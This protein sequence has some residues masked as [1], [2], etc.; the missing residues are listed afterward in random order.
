[1]TGID[2]DWQQAELDFAY[3]LE[4]SSSIY[5]DRRPAASLNRQRF[6][7]PNQLESRLAENARRLAHRPYLLCYEQICSF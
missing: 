3:P 7:N 1:M 6:T 4:V 5:P 2:F